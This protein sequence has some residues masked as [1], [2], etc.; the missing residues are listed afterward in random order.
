VT[1]VAPPAEK[2]FDIQVVVPVEDMTAPGPVAFDGSG[3]FD[4]H[5]QGSA[6]ERTS[7]WP[8]VEERIVDL[9]QA[10]VR[11]SCSPTPVVWPNGSAPG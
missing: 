4:P 5:G 1:I 10:N 8:A 7:V 6:R 9:I 2:L 3:E 11:P